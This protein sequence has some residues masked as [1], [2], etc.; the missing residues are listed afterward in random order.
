M[1]H[2]YSN[3]VLTFWSIS[4]LKVFF[5]QCRRFSHRSRKSRDFHI[6]TWSWFRLIFSESL[7][8]SLQQQQMKVNILKFFCDTLPIHSCSRNA[9]SE[10]NDVY[11]LTQAV[12]WEK[13]AFSMQKTDKKRLKSTHSIYIFVTLCYIVKLFANRSDI[14]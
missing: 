12:M 3:T 14:H 11:I 1:L 7:S 5:R 9:S 6:M 4:T 8:Y 10:L 2:P 13:M